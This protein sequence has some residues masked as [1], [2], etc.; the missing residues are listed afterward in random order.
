MLASLT[1]K[2]AGDWDITLSDEEN[3]NISADV[4]Y[5]SL[6]QL[7]PDELEKKGSTSTGKIIL[8]STVILLCVT[9]VK[10]KTNKN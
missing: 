10:Y 3:M 6:S 9:A 8:A 2:D 7:P 4:S 5:S 1:G